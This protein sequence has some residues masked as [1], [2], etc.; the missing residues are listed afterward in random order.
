MRNRAKVKLETVEVMVQ[1]S[2]GNLNMNP[3]YYYGTSIN[4]ILFTGLDSAIK[5]LDF[6]TSKFNWIEYKFGIAKTFK[7][8]QTKK[9]EIK[10][11]NGTAIETIY[12]FIRC[13]HTY[14]LPIVPQYLYDIKKD[15]I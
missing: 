5:F 9:V 3:L 7:D 6:L 4:P 12:L 1:P 13:D 15:A 10:R 11:F 14:D 8:I 2:F